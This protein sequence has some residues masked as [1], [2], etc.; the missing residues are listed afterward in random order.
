MKTSM[1]INLKTT[2]DKNFNSFKET[3]NGGFCQS[4]QKEVIDFSVLSDK[5]V[6][7]ILKLKGKGSCGR[8]KGSQLNR[9]LQKPQRNPLKRSWGL[10][11]IALLSLVVSPK[12][13]AQSIEN[14]TIEVSE[15]IQ[16]RYLVKGTVF[17]DQN[18]PLVG[19]NVV[20]KGS[21]EGV[22]TNFDG[23]FEFS[24]PLAAGD[25]LVFSY[26][27]FD[28]KEFEIVDS[29]SD[30]ID[31]TIN[32]EASDIILMGEISI[33]TVYSSERKKSKKFTSVLKK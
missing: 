33:D 22:V 14:P 26:V 27:G 19:A 17:D 13:E 5:E 12:A 23:A 11:S 1:Q 21:N 24:R 31:I 3:P 2:C 18:I 30:V 32:F 7:S 6:L 8:F 25:V 9:E 10:A 4:C 29:A 16:N 15:Q 20:L 28:L